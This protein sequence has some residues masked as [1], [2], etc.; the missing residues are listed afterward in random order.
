ME[1][2]DPEL[3]DMMTKEATDTKEQADEITDS[4][5]D[6]DQLGDDKEQIHKQG[7]PRPSV[8]YGNHGP[9][10]SVDDKVAPGEGQIPVNSTIEPDFEALAF[11]KL[12]PCGR[13]HE[14]TDRPKQLR[15]SL[16]YF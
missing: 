6:D 11:P 4:D 3:W 1:E 13:F 7:V 16:A 9:D 15:S 12:F 2:E 5:T 10:I 8:I 14:N